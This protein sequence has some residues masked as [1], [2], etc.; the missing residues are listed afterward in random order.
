MYPRTFLL[1]LASCLS[2]SARFK[3]LSARFDMNVIDA[4]CGVV[5]YKDGF[6][7]G[8]VYQQVGAVYG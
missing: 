6:V 3:K 2:I 5:E 7:Q 4:A 1:A 8:D